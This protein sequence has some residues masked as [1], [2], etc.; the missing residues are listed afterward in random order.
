M[1]IA[2]FGTPAFAVPGL[3]ALVAAGH[4]VAGVVTQPDRPRGRGHHVT[5]APV[6]ARADALGIPVLQPTRLSDAT[7]LD[8][9]RAWH[10][11]IGVVAAYGRLLP[12]VLLD[13]PPRGLVNIHASL[14]PRWRGAAPV[15]RAVIAGDTRTGVTIM[16]VVLAL[17]AGPAL[18]VSETSIA[19]EETSEDLEARLSH[20]GASVL[21][22]TLAALET[23]S[24]I[25]TPQDEHDVTY[26]ARL[27]R[28]DS[29]L[30]WRRPAQDLHNQ[31]RG[32]HPWPLTSAILKG[33]RV[34]LRRSIVASDAPAA[35]AA[36]T[37]IEAH[38]DA[39]VVATGSGALRITEIQPEGGRPL[40]A[41]AFLNGGHARAG[42]V[43]Q[44][45]PDPAQSPER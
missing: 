43:F 40:D 10:T 35:V 33:R 29:H 36:G 34:I 5:A 12:Q 7:F 9:V 4:V 26:A 30:D 13:L 27:T 8:A 28:A 2:Y 32:L 38:A 31:I 17:D 41:R 45:L 19:A 20:L 14:L 16:R 11:D 24:A 25:E 21:V 3:D 39:L 15:H 1:R 6:K 23:G 37:I 42:D 44:P 22:S 18:A